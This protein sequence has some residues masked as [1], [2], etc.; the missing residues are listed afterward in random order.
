M[1]TPQQE[2]ELIF[3]FKGAEFRKTPRTGHSLTL[4]L[5]L[6]FQKVALQKL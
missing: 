2:F 4:I 1:H 5:K 3:A 6:L